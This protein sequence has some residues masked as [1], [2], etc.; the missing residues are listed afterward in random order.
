MIARN[1]LG[2]SR[3]SRKGQRQQEDDQDLKEQRDLGSE[4]LKGRLGEEI[5][6][7]RNPQPRRRYPKPLAFDFQYVQHNQ[8]RQGAEHPKAS[9]IQELERQR[10]AGRNAFAGIMTGHGRIATVSRGN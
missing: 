4:P 10:H 8:R 5:A 6:L 3:R 1:G 9:R 7:S 2:T